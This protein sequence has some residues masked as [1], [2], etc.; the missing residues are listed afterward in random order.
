MSAGLKYFFSKDH[1]WAAQGEDGLWLVGITDYAQNMLGD[2]VFVDPPKVGQSVEQG[3]VCGLIE[4][5]KTGSDLY[6]PLTG[7]VD[8]VNEQALSSPERINDH[9]YDTWLFKLAAAASG[10]EGLLD[11][12]A[13]ESQL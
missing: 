2:V 13:Y 3:A 12:S 11:Q 1:T 5:V 6:A 7:V 8:A 10:A 9:P 4:S